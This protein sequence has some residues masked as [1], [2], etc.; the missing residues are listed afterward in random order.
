MYIHFNVEFRELGVISLD[1]CK[2]LE[3]VLQFTL[4]PRITAMEL[5]DCEETTMYDVNFEKEMRRKQ[6]QKQQGAYDEDEDAAPRVPKQIR[7]A[8]PNIGKVGLEV[9]LQ[10]TTKIVERRQVNRL[11][12]TMGLAP[13]VHLPL[14]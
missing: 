7:N 8:L 13:G 9:A 6:Q 12:L 14:H 1:Q 5:D 11:L 10:K 4:S 2:K 3:A